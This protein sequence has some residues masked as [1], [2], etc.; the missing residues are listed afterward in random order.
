MHV[1]GYIVYL[2]HAQSYLVVVMLQTVLVDLL[3]Y[4][5]LLMCTDGGEHYDMIHYRQHVLIEM[6]YDV[7]HLWL[8]IENGRCCAGSGEMVEVR[9]KQK[10]TEFDINVCFR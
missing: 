2:S 10:H 5:M 1:M 6:H 3:T 8:T 7:P 4:L 9:Q